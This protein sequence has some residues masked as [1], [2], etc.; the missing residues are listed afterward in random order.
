[1]ETLPE[2]TVY[3]VHSSDKHYIIRGLTE[4]DHAVMMVDGDIDMDTILNV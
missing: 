1:M 3:L 2:L 4:D